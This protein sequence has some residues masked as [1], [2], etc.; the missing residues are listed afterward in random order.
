MLLN[1]IQLICSGLHIEREITHLEIGPV[2]WQQN[3]LDLTGSTRE[4]H[5]FW[6]VNHMP[7]QSS[8]LQAY[9][10]YHSVSDFLGSTEVSLTSPR[11]RIIGFSGWFWKTKTY[12]PS[13]HSYRGNCKY[14]I[15]KHQ[16]SLNARLRIHRAKTP[17]T[18]TSVN[19]YSLPSE[20]KMY[21]IRRCLCW[22]EGRTHL[23][24]IMM[25]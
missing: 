7:T 10:C 19:F 1:S 17:M 23:T 5:R 21:V 14:L 11:Q 2:S 22:G 13:S 20:E 6:M 18:M 12:F 24:K 9:K 8:E 25:L 3:T 4:S 16:S 15:W